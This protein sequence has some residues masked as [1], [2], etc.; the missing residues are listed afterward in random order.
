MAQIVAYFSR[1][2][3]NYVGG[4]IKNLAVGNMEIAANK[5]VE[6]TGAP[7]F[8][9]KPLVAYSNHYNDCIEQARQDL[10]RDARPELACWPES[11]EQYDIIYLGYPNYWGTMP[12]AVCTFL[13]RYDFSGKAIRPFCTHE[14][15]GMGSSETD[16]RRLCPGAKL[17]QGLAI[18]GAKVKDAQG[19]IKQWLQTR[20]E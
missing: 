11:M 9:I 19:A 15:S 13:E 16:I 18:P 12:M 5:L 8:Q 17:E 6:V 2:G 7:L 1:A 10:K 3:E 20:G 14:G 4:A